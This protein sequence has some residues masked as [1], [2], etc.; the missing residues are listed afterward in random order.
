[1][2]LILVHQLTKKGRDSLCKKK[3][4]RWLEIGVISVI[5]LL[6]V[7]NLLGTVAYASS[8]VD[9]TIDTNNIYSTYSL[10]HYQLDFMWIT[11]GTGCHGIGQMVLENL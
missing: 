5:L 1:M 4:F 6:I 7:A 3:W 9:T 2:R 10:D 8:L 11:Q